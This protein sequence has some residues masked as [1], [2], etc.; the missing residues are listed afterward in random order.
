[1]IQHIDY[2][3][4]GCERS[5]FDQIFL[6]LSSVFVSSDVLHQAESIIRNHI[7]TFVRTFQSMH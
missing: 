7:D 2:D 6:S 4:L 1:M 5:A 3:A